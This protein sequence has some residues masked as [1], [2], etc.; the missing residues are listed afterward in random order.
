M[1]ENSKGEMNKEEIIVKNYYEKVQKK[2]VEEHVDVIHDDKLHEEV[3]IGDDI[4]NIEEKEFDGFKVDQ[5]PENE[6]V[7]LTKED[8]VFNYYYVEVSSG[9]IEKHIDIVT[10]E[11]LD[12]V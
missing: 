5:I 2:V 10:N 9:V 6:T 3:H 4:T 11:I 12:S 1:P 7:T 8:I